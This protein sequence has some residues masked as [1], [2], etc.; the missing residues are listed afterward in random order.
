LKFWMTAEQ[1]RTGFIRNREYWRPSV[2]K[3]IN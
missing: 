2:K 1:S 3:T